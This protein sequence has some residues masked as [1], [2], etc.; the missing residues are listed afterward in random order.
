M[1]NKST[2]EREI[3]AAKVKVYDKKKKELKIQTYTSD[4]LSSFFYEM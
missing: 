2:R 4:I 3:A 1:A